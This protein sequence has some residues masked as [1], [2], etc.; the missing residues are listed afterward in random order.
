MLF[1]YINYFVY[2]WIAMLTNDLEKRI[3]EAFEVFDHACNKTVVIR[4]VGTIIRSL[5]NNMYINYCI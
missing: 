1:T 3:V 4:E 2:G 5:G